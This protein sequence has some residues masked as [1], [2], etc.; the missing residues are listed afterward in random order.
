[1]QDVCMP[2]FGWA[3]VEDHIR[4]ALVKTSERVKGNVIVR[5]FQDITGVFKKECVLYR[6]IDSKLAVHT[7]I[8]ARLFRVALVVNSSRIGGILASEVV[9]VS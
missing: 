6:V 3:I 9:V 1:M 8:F 4:D 7:E 2:E 5:T